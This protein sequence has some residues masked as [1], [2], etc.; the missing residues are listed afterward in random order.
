MA[1]E[2]A[3]RRPRRRIPE[4]D[5][6]VP[7]GGRQHFTARREYHA[8]PLAVE[9]CTNFLARPATPQLFGHDFVYMS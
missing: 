4:P 6:S 9:G 3:E 8:I 1:L 7:C 5:R 2:R